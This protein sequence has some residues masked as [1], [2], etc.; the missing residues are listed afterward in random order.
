[1]ADRIH[2]RHSTDKQTD[3]RQRH[4]LAARLAAGAPKTI[5]RILDAA[6]ARNLPDQLALSPADTGEPALDPDVVLDLPGLLVE[7]RKVPAS[8][9]T[10]LYQRDFSFRCSS[11]PGSATSARGGCRRPN[12]PRSAPW[13]TT[14]R[15][16]GRL[17][18]RPPLTAR[19]RC[20]VVERVQVTVDGAG[21]N[22]HAVVTWAGGH[23]THADLIRPVARID[24]DATARP[25]RGHGA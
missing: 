6:G 18:R 4:V 25:A 1:M 3:A 11:R 17:Q 15:P 5:H 16:C 23:R 2:L 14:S 24:R 10:Q 8:R 12:W 7:Q 9:S 20:A 21:E 13:P 22:I 19:S